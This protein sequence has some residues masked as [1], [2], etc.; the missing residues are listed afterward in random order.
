MV[1]AE[2]RTVPRYKC[3]TSP[4][5]ENRD[6]SKI[7]DNSA[8]E[9]AGLGE[10]PVKERGVPMDPS[11]RCGINGKPTHPMIDHWNLESS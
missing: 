8:A 5:A 4:G 10:F 2:A 1:T 3:L 9:Y 11:D 7:R 6:A